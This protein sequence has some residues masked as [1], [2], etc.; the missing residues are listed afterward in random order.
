MDKLLLVSKMAYK[1]AQQKLHQGKVPSF[2]GLEGMLALMYERL[3]QYS[4]TKDSD[5]VLD[6]AA[7]SIL[8]LLHI[9]PDMDDSDHREEPQQE[10]DR[11]EERPENTDEAIE[12]EPDRQ[13]TPVKP[14]KTLE[15]PSVE[16]EDA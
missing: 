8:A 1:R 2:L 3:V 16:N 9:V 4:D 13:W 12:E 15:I 11:E 14:G 5:Y 10:E 7:D 6:L